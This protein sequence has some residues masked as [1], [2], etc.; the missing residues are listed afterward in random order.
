MKKI[1][2]WTNFVLFLL[3]LAFIFFILYQNRGISVKFDY[4]FGESELV[5]PA[6]ISLIFLTGAVCG[7]IVTLILSI[8]NFGT[9]WRQRRELKAT[10]KSLKKL[11]EE[12][13]L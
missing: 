6:L 3:F 4:L 1:I 10:K 12:T 9:S 13:A 7:I 2:K 11:Q 5:L 8:G